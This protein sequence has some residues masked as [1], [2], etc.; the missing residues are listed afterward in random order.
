MI[1]TYCNWCKD[2]NNPSP[3]NHPNGQPIH[4]VPPEE[5]NGSS[6]IHKLPHW[7][8]MALHRIADHAIKT[9]DRPELFP[10]LKDPEKGCPVGPD[11][12][13]NCEKSAGIYAASQ[14]ILNG[15]EMDDVPEKVP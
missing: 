5:P 3:E 4:Y 1:V 8:H 13:I 2:P 12:C 11:R 10:C 6:I 14:W 7:L 9:L 15:M